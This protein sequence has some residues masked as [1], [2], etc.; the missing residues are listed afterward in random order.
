MYMLI[1]GGFVAALF[2][3]LAWGVWRSGEFDDDE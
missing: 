1:G 2:G 3:I